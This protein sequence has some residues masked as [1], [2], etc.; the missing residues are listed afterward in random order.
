MSK[1]IK[2][3]GVEESAALI[4]DYQGWIIEIHQI[5]IRNAN[6]IV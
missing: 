2:T 3:I 5:L 4:I 1:K 6:C